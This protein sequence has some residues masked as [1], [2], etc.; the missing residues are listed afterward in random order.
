MGTLQYDTERKAMSEAKRLLEE[1]LGRKIRHKEYAYPID[2]DI[3]NLTIENLELITRKDPRSIWFEED[4]ERK[5][6]NWELLG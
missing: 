2:G 6:L 4:E 1:K 5:P 3:F